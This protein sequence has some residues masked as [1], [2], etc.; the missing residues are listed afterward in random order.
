MNAAKFC[1]ESSRFGLGFRHVSDIDDE[2]ISV[3]RKHRHG[4][5]HGRTRLVKGSPEYLKNSNP[6]VLRQAKEQCFCRVRRS[7][8]DPVT[9]CDLPQAELVREVFDRADLDIAGVEELVGSFEDE[10]HRVEGRL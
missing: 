4:K 5:S 8:R 9:I 3:C 7:H 2:L 6:T 1:I 10:A